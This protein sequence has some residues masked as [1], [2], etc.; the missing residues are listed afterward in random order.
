M[1]KVLCEKFD[2]VNISKRKLD[3]SRN[4]VSKMTTDHFD[5]KLEHVVTKDVKPEHL[6]EYAESLVKT[7][8]LP[9]VEEQDRVCEG[10][11]QLK[12]TGGDGGKGMRM[13]EVSYRNHSWSSIYGV[14]VVMKNEEGNY[15]VE[16]ALHKVKFNITGTGLG[17][18]V[19]GSGSNEI[20]IS[21]E[22]IEAIK[23]AYCRHKALTTMK[24]E[25]IIDHINY[26]E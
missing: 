8:G 20:N 3:A 6:D 17:R 13:L 15:N 5:E 4:V 1:N 2:E 9:N 23:T 16:Y 12:F 26:T 18:H 7:L 21:P 24:D 11:K 19:L 14:L 10:M 22:D 25:G